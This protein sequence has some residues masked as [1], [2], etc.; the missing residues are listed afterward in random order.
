MSAVP[1]ESTFLVLD[2]IRR[3]STAAKV[4]VW[5][6]GVSSPARGVK[7]RGQKAYRIVWGR[8]S[9]LREAHEK[10]LWAAACPVVLEMLLGL[11][12]NAI[13]GGLEGLQELGQLCVDLW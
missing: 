11:R 8:L 1:P 3:N 6:R 13:V 10:D 9:L 4:R 2:A 12:A 5:E 7:A